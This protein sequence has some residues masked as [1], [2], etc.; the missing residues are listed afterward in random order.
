MS[1]IGN[2]PLYTSYVADRFSGNGSTLA[3]TLSIAPANSASLLVAIYG[4]LQ[5]PT[6]YGVVGNTLTFSS[7]PPAGTNNISVRYL[8]L[9][10]SNVVT[11]SYRTVTDIIATAGQT[12]FSPASY[13]PGF[14]DVYRN[15][16]KLAAAD[17]T[18]TNGAQV[19]LANAAALG[20]IIQT[21]SFSVG[22]VLNSLQASAGVINSGYLADGSVGPSKLDQS[23]QLG[24]GAVSLPA[25]ATSQRPTG[26]T[27]GYTR[28][29]TT[30][31]GLEFWNGS[32]WIILGNLDG[33]TEARAAPSAAYLKNTMGITTNGLYWIKNSRMTYA[34]QVYCDFTYDSGGW[35]LLSYGFLATTGDSSSN[36]AM[37]NLN[38][39]RPTGTTY[40]YNPTNRASTYGLVSNSYSVQTALLLAQGSSQMM[41][42]AGGNPSSGGIDGYTNVYRIEI[43]NPNA[44]TFANHSYTYGG[45]SMNVSAVTVTG[46]KGDIG[47]WTR[48]T[49]T[50]AIGATWSDTYPTGYGLV[51]NSTVR[52]WNGDGGPFF[53]SVHS[54]SRTTAAPTNPALQTA[55]PDIGVNGF[56]QGARSYSYR[57]WYGSTSVNNTGQMSIWVR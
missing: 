57:G 23:G 27:N 54:G 50:E 14:I 19:V 48:W 38:H 6:A 46:L 9:P 29:N 36:Y 20:D 16:A 51:S 44:L 17:F 41:F 1:Y 30:L 34:A 28:Y 3:Y 42:A 4:V 7:P 2:Q 12:T 15:G 11:S 32:T 52:G 26:P 31:S 39:D 5:D 45:A 47:T 21:V 22:S 33:S 37:P 43:P 24:T 8:G 25:G 40:S 55:S 56:Q 13:T 18:A 49:F 35:M 10:A 53:P